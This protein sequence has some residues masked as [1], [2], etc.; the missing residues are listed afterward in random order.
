M[1]LELREMVNL[2]GATPNFNK[3]DFHG[4]ESVISKLTR[5]RKRLTELLVKTAL[6]KPTEKQNELWAKGTKQWHLK[7]LRTPLEIMPSSDDPQTVGKIK[8]GINELSQGDINESQNVIDTGE[9][10]T[11]DCGLVLRSI[12]YK[13]IRKYY[14][15]H[16]MENI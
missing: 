8:L 9:T 4:M 12:G 1:F 16:Q 11:I 14:S 7:L 6:D 15:S 10:E 2:E 5:P 3:R 13:S